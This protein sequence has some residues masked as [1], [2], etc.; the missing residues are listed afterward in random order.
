MDVWEAVGARMHPPPLTDLGEGGVPPRVGVEGGD[1]HQPVD[2]CLALAPPVR[3][4]AAHLLAAFIVF[5]CFMV[6]CGRVR[7][8]RDMSACTCV[9]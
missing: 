8:G 4:G 7:N 5:V 9:P 6:G 2:A 1:A 3:Q